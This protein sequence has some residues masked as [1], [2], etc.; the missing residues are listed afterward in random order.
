[1][2]YDWC[3]RQKRRRDRDRHTEG[4]ALETSEAEIV[5]QQLRAPECPGM[6]RN[7]RSEEGGMEQILF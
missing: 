5:V 7:L 2:Q 6:P 4:S 1:M 3:P